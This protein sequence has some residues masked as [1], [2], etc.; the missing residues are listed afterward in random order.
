WQ[1]PPPSSET[2][3]SVAA[4]PSGA[5]WASTSAG[6]GTA[7]VRPPRFATAAFGCR[8]WAGEPRSANPAN[9]TTTASASEPP[10]RFVHRMR[11]RRRS[12]PRRRAWAVDDHER[13]EVAD[14]IRSLPG[15]E[16]VGDVAADDEE[17]VGI[18]A[19]VPQRL[20][21]VG[22]VRLTAAVNLDPARLEAPDLADRRLDEGKP[23]LRRRDEALALLL[24]GDVGHDEQ[25]ALESE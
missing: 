3:I 12:A 20:Q 6:T 10:A 2:S 14:H 17:E 5:G 11:R 1:P 16:L 25:D 18:G 4:D 13:G 21:R 8:V 23:V 22:R 9:A 7:C 19:R 15:H 24:P